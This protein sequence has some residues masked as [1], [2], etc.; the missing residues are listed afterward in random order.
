MDKV[1]RLTGNTKSGKNGF[2]SANAAIEWGNNAKDVI[3]IY[4]TAVIKKTS[5]PLCSRR[6]ALPTNASARHPQKEG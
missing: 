6:C 5:I 1:C 4:V 3:T 2:S